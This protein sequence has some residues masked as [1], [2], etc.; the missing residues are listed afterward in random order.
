MPTV[1]YLC[2]FAVLFAGALFA[3]LPAKAAAD[4]YNDAQLQLLFSGSSV[5]GNVRLPCVQEAGGGAEIS[6]DWEF[7]FNI[8]GT[9]AIKYVCV[10]TYRSTNRSENGTWRVQNN[11]LCV[12]SESDVFDSSLHYKERC[13]PVAWGGRFFFEGYVPDG[14]VYWFLK[15]NNPKFPSKKALLGALEAIGN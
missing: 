14:N 2:L 11:Q 15:I 10:D 1:R 9:L 5:V 7:T 6:L 12:D 13:W 4:T 8:D 3:A